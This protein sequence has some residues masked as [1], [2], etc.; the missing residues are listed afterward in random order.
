MAS[1]LEAAE[2]SPDKH[3]RK[4]P[5][6]KIYKDTYQQ[7]SEQNIVMDRFSNWL[8]LQHTLVI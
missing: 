4:N 1:N 2:T 8:V 6:T 3:M 5:T 7:I